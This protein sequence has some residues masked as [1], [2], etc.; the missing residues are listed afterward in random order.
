[1]DSATLSAYS[2][3]AAAVATS[4]V[5][6]LT[7]K[8][9]RDGQRQRKESKKQFTDT[10]EATERHH[11]DSFRPVV[12]LAP[13]NPMDTLVGSNLVSADANVKIIKL[14]CTALNIG[15][16]AALNL[17]LSVRGE[18]RTG[19]GASRALSPMAAGD[20]LKN[21]NDHILINVQF[22][23]QFNIADLSNL[24]HGYWVVAIEYEDIFGNRFHTLHHRNA[25]LPWARVGRGPA[26]DT[27]PRTLDLTA[28]LPV[29]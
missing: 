8:A 2:T 3:A 20:T 14:E 21:R 28:E 9:L 29:P 13:S 16:G 1:M 26:P 5:A 7:Y 22:N 19:F 6:L 18:G 11:Q 27:T 12:V 24:P 17:K 15:S 25:A 23:D 4:I 10:Q